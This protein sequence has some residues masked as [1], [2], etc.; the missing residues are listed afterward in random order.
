KRREERHR[1]ERDPFVAMV[2]DSSGKQTPVMS[3]ARVIA[4][5]HRITFPSPDTRM[6]TPEKTWQL[7]IASLRASDPKA[8]L[9]CFTSNMRSKLEMLFSKMTTEDMRR[10]AE[11]FTAFSM[12]EGD[13]DMREAVL[14]RTIG[15]RKNAGFA[16]F[17][18][19]S[20]EWRIDS[21]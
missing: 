3:V 19:Q 1:E 4:K 21:M 7:F 17:V 15:E 16:Y 11:S 20:G 2:K 9:G 6:A 13:G 10:M 8:A 5:E 18:R 14:V 12:Q